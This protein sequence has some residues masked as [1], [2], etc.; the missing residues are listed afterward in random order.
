VVH[1]KGSLLAKQAGDDWQRFANLRL[2]Y[3]YMFAQP[4]KKLLFMGAELAQRAEWNHDTSLDWHLLQHAPHAGVARLVRDLNHLYRDEPALHEL[5][6]EAHGFRWIEADDAEHSVLA[7]SRHPRSTTDTAPVVVVVNAT[8]LPRH[9]YRIGVERE[10]TY[11]E[12]L[13]TDALPYGGSGIG[14]LGL[15][16]AEPIAAQHRP[17]SLSL[18]LPPMA[19]LFLRMTA[20]E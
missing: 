9:G 11:A 6:A 15:T 7:F 1:G 10:G 19:A 2:L 8:P 20:R 17:Y 16:T 14:N 12:L 3:A 18:T 4:G 5:D 13:N